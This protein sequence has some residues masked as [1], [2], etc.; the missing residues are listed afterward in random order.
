VRDGI[1]TA[2]M[3]KK[4]SLQAAMAVEQIDIA[5]SGVSNALGQVDAVERR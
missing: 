4:A 5:Q 1:L 2:N 3:L